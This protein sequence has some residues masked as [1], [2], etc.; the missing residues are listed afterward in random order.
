MV[1][2]AAWEDRVGEGYDG[3]DGSLMNMKASM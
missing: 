2:S 3:G 1:I